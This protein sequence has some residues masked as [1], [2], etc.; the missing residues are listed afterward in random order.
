MN[1]IPRIGLTV[2]LAGCD[3]GGGG[4]GVLTPDVDAKPSPLSFGTAYLGIG[5]TRQLEI[6]N[7]GGAKLSVS[8][9]RLSEGTHPGV[10]VTT[11]AFELE[12]ARSRTISVAFVPLDVGPAHGSVVIDSDDPDEPALEIPIEGS[13]ERRPGPVIAV[14]P[15]RIDFGAV[16][17]GETVEASITVRSVGTLPLEILSAM[18]ETN[19][20]PSISFDPASLSGVVPVDGS[21][22]IAVRFSP[23]VP[24]EVSAVLQIRSNDPEIAFVSVIVTGSGIAPTLCL[25]SSVLDFGRVAIG[26]YVDRTVTLESCGAVAFDL[27]ALDTVGTMEFTIQAFPSLPLE[28]GPGQTADVTIRYAPIDGGRDMSQLRI[29][30]TLPDGFVVLIGE[31]AACDLV[32]TPN[33]VNFNAVGTGQSRTRTVLLENPGGVDCEVTAVRLTPQ[34]SPEF[35]FGPVSVPSTIVPGS[36][37]SIDVA[38]APSDTG[39]DNGALEIASNDPTDP[40]LTVDLTG[41]RLAPGECA[42]VVTPDP[43]AFGTVP[44]GTTRMMQASIENV[45]GNIC[46]ILQIALSQASSRDFFLVPPSIPMLIPGG[47]TRTVDLEYAPRTSQPQTGDLEIFAGLVPLTPDYVIPISGAGSGPELCLTPN[48]L[49]F[50]THMPGQPI[51]RQ[52]QVSACGTEDV[53]ISQITFPPPTSAEYTVASPPGL[54]WTLAAGTLATLDVVYTGANEGR[55][56]GVLRFASNDA[57]SPNRDVQLIAHSSSGPCGDIQ[58]RLCDLTGNGPVIGGTVYVDTPMGRIQ[59]TTNNLGDWVLTCVPLGT[60]TVN[61]EQ[62]SWSTSF[63]AN[64]QPNTVTT[65]P[66]QQCLDSTS[67]EVA[68][69]W[70]QWDQMQGILSA[71]GVSYTLYDETQTASLVNDPSELALYDVIFFNCGW[72]ELLGLGNPGLSNITSF[73]MNGGSIYSSDYAYDLVEVGWPGF[74]DFYGDDLQ[75]DAAQQAGNFNGVVD[76][77][78]PGLV[79]A[80]GGR[81]RVPIQSCCTAIDSVAMGAV[82]YLTGDRY[83]DGG[84]HPLMIGF[85]PSMTSGKVF[86]TDFHNTGQADIVDIFNWL[87]LQ[88]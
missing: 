59:T 34:T 54:P 14:D 58:G 74:A 77:A 45:G 81:N 67:A 38:Y 24:E 30:S 43:I 76:V 78:D 7:R 56:D 20:H 31:A 71:I 62:G 55:D 9:V 26:E 84:S 64:V 10:S 72:N 53:V 75:L 8:G 42:L 57:G 39:T 1:G 52:L 32:A 3:C 50:G 47:Q 22:V 83:N 80:L 48:P 25:S 11:E 86:Y 88:L 33:A 19:S 73:V 79:A 5:A 70:G 16:A 69:V 21:R 41:R 65:L 27:S 46:T 68:V 36:S 18:P 29:Q 60:W 61:A 23:A 15:L 49:V 87:I 82:G 51:A 17:F 6:S 40:T 13:G 85:Q 2:L 4:L 44:I 28:L 37:L 12:P 66:G 63:P 35:S